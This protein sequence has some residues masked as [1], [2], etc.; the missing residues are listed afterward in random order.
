MKKYLVLCIL[1]LSIPFAASAAW[2]SPATWSPLDWLMKPAVRDEV[3]I[4]PEVE[5][6]AAVIGSE[7]VI[8][9]STIAT[10][11]QIR[12]DDE[13]VR[14]L[15]EE[16]ALL[17]TEVKK[18]RSSIL[19]CTNALSAS[20]ISTAKPVVKTNP[21]LEIRKTKLAEVDKKAAEFLDLFDNLSKSYDGIR[22]LKVDLLEQFVGQ[23]NVIV[24]TYRA[25][26]P[27]FYAREITMS[28]PLHSQ[29][30]SFIS[31]LKTYRALNPIN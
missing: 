6:V 19:Q 30:E 26:D 29:F 31:Y 4:E 1:F 23:V 27:M 17:T 5:E 10:T 3:V 9:T 22:G 28:E 11:T 14:K 8:A 13:T 25:L 7:I 21:L 2:W 18:L 20:A 12:V 16:N 24:S 15:K